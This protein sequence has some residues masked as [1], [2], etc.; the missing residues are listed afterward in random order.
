MKFLVSERKIYLHCFL[1]GFN[2]TWWQLQILENSQE[3]RQQVEI[4]LSRGLGIRQQ[5]FERLTGRCLA[6]I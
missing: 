2:L 1:T 5:V 4:T 3:L 6:D